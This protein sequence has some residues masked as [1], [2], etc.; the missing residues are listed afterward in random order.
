MTL[1]GINF[2][3]YYF[4]KQGLEEHYDKEFNIRFKWDLD[5]L[6]GYNFEFLDIETPF[7][8]YDF[9]GV[10]LLSNFKAISKRDNLTYVFLQGWQVIA[11][12]QVIKQIYFSNVKVIMRGDSNHLLKRSTFKKAAKFIP[13]YLLFRKVD[14]F[15]F[16]GR[17]NKSYYKD[18]KIPESKLL[19]SPHYVDNDFFKKNY[20]DLH[21]QRNA[22]IKK[23][24]L[25]AAK[26]TILF[27]G[28]L[29]SKK[30]PQTIIEALKIEA[31]DFQV[32][33][34]GSGNLED[35]LKEISKSLPV[36]FTGF[37][38]QTEISE[39]YIVADCLILP[40]DANETWGLVVNE[41]MASN[42]PVI[43]SNMCGVSYDLVYPIDE[44]LVF[45]YQ[46]SKDL[47]RAICYL[48]DDRI[49]LI[50]SKLSIIDKYTPLTTIH[51]L[52]RIIK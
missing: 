25:N 17:K 32:L 30:S 3:V 27:V 50:K 40:S 7:K 16:V 19:F 2:K 29:I 23:F 46:N 52:I 20:E 42:L 39:A 18:F 26:K 45:K 36:F 15:F 9:N 22:L 5:L 37:L 35:Y 1:A 51:N 11:Y 49:D 31:N 13:I 43:S 4:C 21:P 24:G 48:F 28:K 8:M 10:K 12:W 38:N 44:N 41:A 34:V 14:Y 6:S 33:F 47:W